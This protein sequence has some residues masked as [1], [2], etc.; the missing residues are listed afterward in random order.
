ML[1][2]RW[3]EL[4]PSRGVGGAEGLADGG[5][6]SPKSPWLREVSDG[7]GRGGRMEPLVREWE[8]RMGGVG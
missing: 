3:K 5:R 8:R 4:S 2:L 1:R 7:G 6:S